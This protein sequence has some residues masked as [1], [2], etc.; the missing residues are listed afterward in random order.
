MVT[1]KK[2]LLALS[3]GA[4]GVVFGDIG[5]SPLYAL[6]AVFGPLGLNF[7]P[8]PSHVYGV[9]SLIIWSVTLVVTI[10][11]LVFVMRAD[12][13]GEGGILALV[14]LLKESKLR[15]SSKWFFI[16]IGLIGVSLFYGD[17]VITPAI[18]VLSAV[19]GLKLVAPSLGQV[20]VPL[21]LVI[22]TCLFA[23][24]RFGTGVIGRL[25]GPVMVIW[26]VTIGLGGAWRLMQDPDALQALSPLAGIHFFHAQPLFALLAMGAVVLAITGAEALYAD[27]GHFGRGPIARSWLLLVF[28]A[29]ALCY[30]GQGAILVHGSNVTQSTFFQLFPAVI[31]FPMVILAA[32]ATFIASQSVIS[33][34]FSLT[35][36][37]IQLGFLPRMRILHTSIKRSGQIYL[38]L[39]NIILY[40]LVATL[41]VTF[42]SSER[43]AS[44]YG[45]AV[46]G[47]L[48]TDT[49]LFLVVMRVTGRLR[50]IYLTILA[51]IFMPIDATFII[52]NAPK[53]LHGGWFPITVAVVA[54]TLL[55]TWIKGEARATKERLSL[56]GSTGAFVDQVHSARPAIQRSPGVAVYIGHHPG[57]TPLALRATL[58]DLH[59]LPQKVVIVSVQTTNAAH[60][61]EDARAI[62]DELGYN[63]GICQLKLRYGFH[64]M[65]NVPL[66]LK[67][68]RPLSPELDFDPYKASYFV[69]LSKITPSH[70]RKMAMWRK[71]LF[72]FMARNELSPSDYF[73]LPIKRT[74]EMTT[75]IKL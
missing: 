34:A 39:V 43:L 11:Y 2:S 44:A 23:I 63:D 51:A 22:L 4:I 56:E 30:T 59:E 37:A 73:R 29:L 31:R 28:P 9:I 72:T 16:L 68:V 61:N 45:I 17:S 69:S 27:M 33:G 24:Q 49:I 38:P 54:F 36:Q 62:Y 12:N 65:I 35:R 48:A 67:M 66:A 26:F 14:A 7:A 41:V 42:G 8:T 75:L 64:D 55:T 71:H 32:V 53:F 70:S 6:Q 5:T 40:I 19:E 25:F 10:K 20:I 52:S 15:P 18:S 21:T 47:T 3:I 74:E 58:D 60:I 50:T 46:S 57:F 13:G 1:A